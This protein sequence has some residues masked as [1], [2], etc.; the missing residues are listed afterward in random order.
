MKLIN[1]LK[2]CGD[3]PKSVVT[4][5]Q[6]GKKYDIFLSIVICFE[7]NLVYL[8]IIPIV[9]TC[10]SNNQMSLEIEGKLLEV[11]TEQS[12]E[13]KNGTWRKKSFVIETGDQ[14]PKKVCFVV[15]GDRINIL[16][17][18][19]QGDSLKVSFDIESREYNGRWYTDVKAWRIEGQQT[20]QAAGATG[21]VEG[22]TP[23]DPFPDDLMSPKAGQEDDLPF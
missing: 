16:D 23:D 7:Q 1:F 5:P 9:I 21:T 12:G 6:N 14:Y 11:H 15:W 20:Q 10:K 19:S 13:G 2:L 8:F 18:F 17:N 22:G 4:L 3:N